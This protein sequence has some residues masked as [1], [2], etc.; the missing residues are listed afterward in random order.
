MQNV[1]IQIMDEIKKVIVGKDAVIAKVLMAILLRRTSLLLFV[2]T[3]QAF[4]TAVTGSL[5][6]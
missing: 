4:L 3:T 5:P 2:T 6:M 1:A